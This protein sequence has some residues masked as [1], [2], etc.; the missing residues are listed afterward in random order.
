MRT[1]YNLKNALFYGKYGIRITMSKGSY[2]LSFILFFMFIQHRKPQ[3]LSDGELYKL[4]QEYGG[5][6]RMFLRKFAGLLPEVYRRHLYK[7]RS[8]ASIHEFAAKLAGM[9]HEA[10]DKI[11]RLAERL[12]DKPKLLEQLESGSQPWSKIEAVSF[13]AEKETDGLFAEKVATLPRPALQ[14]YVKIYRSQSAA[15]GEREH[16]MEIPQDTEKWN[17]ISFHADP[18]T[19]KQLRL[20]KQQF[21][22]QNKK[23]MGWNEV[24]NN[25]IKLCKENEKSKNIKTVTTNVCPSCEEQKE[26]AREQNGETTRYIPAEARKIIQ[27]RSG[28]ICEYP[29]CRTPGQILHHTRRYA[30][31][32]NHDPQ[33]IRNLCK[34]HEALLQN[35]L[36]ENENREPSEWEIR[37]TPDRDSPKFNI[38]QFVAQHRMRFLPNAS[39]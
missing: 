23:S 22:K 30:L 35:G 4:C 8:C 21:E 15:C 1:F 38:D 14:E 33:Y 27:Q 31:R 29:N 39:S 17:R 20:L 28:G 5:N 7:K 37:N 25:M 12:K 34:K 18:E 10:T 26:N 2:F 9:S 6:A 11:L 13:I 16:T 32:K 3:D 36:I 19:E 24:M